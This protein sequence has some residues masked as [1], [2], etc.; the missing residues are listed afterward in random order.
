MPNAQ[1]IQQ[2]HDAKQALDIAQNHFDFAE[3]EFIDSAVYSLTSAI[4]RFDAVYSRLK[5]FRP[6]ELD[7]DGNGG[8]TR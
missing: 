2:L 8:R 6:N 1:Q 5:K 3:P 7:K 4:S